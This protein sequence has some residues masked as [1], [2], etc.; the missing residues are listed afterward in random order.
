MPVQ[1]SIPIV[2]QKISTNSSNVV[3]PA[4]FHHQKKTSEVVFQIPINKG[5]IFHNKELK[6]IAEVRIF[7][8]QQAPLHYESPILEQ[9]EWL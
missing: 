6:V 3:I 1:L 5:I 4:S 9:L 8:S 2:N 7:G